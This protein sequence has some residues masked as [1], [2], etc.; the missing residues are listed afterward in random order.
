MLSGE[1]CFGKYISF[2]NWDPIA[3]HA[4]NSVNL[5]LCDMS[6]A[7]ETFNPV[8]SMFLL[9]VNCAAGIICLVC[10]Y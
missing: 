2:I 4:L 3:I 7:S 1:G 10:F 9:S 6:L 5:S 8:R